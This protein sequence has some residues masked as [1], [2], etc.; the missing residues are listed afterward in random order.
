MTVLTAEFGRPPRCTSDTQG[1]SVDV[2]GTGAR[3]VAALFFCMLV[4]TGC[5]D[6]ICVFFGTSVGA[7]GIDNIGAA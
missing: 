6:N 5:F 4:V 3:A 7:C 1:T 2:P